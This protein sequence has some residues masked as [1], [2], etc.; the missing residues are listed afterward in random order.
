VP[1]PGTLIANLADMLAPTRKFIALSWLLLGLGGCGSGDEFTSNV[2]GNYTV[3]LTNG[4]SSCNFEQWMVG[5]ETTG[6]GLAITQDGK[7]VHATVGDPT[8]LFF[9]VA[10]GSADFDGSIQ[11]NSFTLTNYG[12]RTAN[13][14][15]CSYTYNATVEA[16]QSGDSIS[17]TITYATKT[18]GNPDCDAVECSA[19]QEFNGSRPPQ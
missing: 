12:Q 3:A 4:A 15:N 16:T 19:S 14:G 11:G 2:A 5:Q 10:F 8:A 6:V 1:T 7:N 9:T 17:G 18:N 13:Q